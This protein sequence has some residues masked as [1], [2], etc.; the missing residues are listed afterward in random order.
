MDEREGIRMKRF[1]PGD[2]DTCVPAWQDYKREFLILL[3]AKGL[4]EKPGKRKVGTLLQC[5]G[6][7]C[8]KIYDTFEW[9]PAIAAIAANADNHIE[10]VPARAAEEKTNLQHVFQK[11]DQYWGVN[12]YRAIKRQEFLDMKRKKNDK[13]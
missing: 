8:I 1:A 13:G 10:A 7:E 2:I 6:M 12:R 4:D 9:A 11:F 5:M 3:D